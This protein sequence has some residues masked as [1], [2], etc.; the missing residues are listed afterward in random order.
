[1]RATVAA[2]IGNMCRG[3]RIMM[4]FLG[5]SIAWVV[6]CLI[7]SAIVVPVMWSKLRA[8]RVLQAMHHAREHRDE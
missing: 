2:R 3:E 8:R 7:A 6:P 4:T 5:S 1:M